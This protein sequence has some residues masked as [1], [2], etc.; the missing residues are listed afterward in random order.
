[1]KRTLK[2]GGVETQM[3]IAVIGL[4]YVGLANAVLLAQHN[5]VIA[6]DIIKERV[7]MVNSR[8]SP[9]ADQVVEEYLAKES[10]H[11]QATMDY[12]VALKDAVY[13][14]ISKDIKHGFGISRKSCLEHFSD[15]CASC[16]TY[17]R[18]GS[19]LSISSNRSISSRLGMLTQPFS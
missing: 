13:A 12:E 1:M 14:V 4:G 16:Y 10:L 15:S 3:K 6:V 18:E 7:D 19:F 9:I 8:K 2:I 5:D 17:P 11:L